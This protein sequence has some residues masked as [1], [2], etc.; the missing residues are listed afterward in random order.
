MRAALAHPL[1]PKFGLGFVIAALTVLAG[2]TFGVGLASADPTPEPPVLTPKPVAPTEVKP[3]F[4][5]PKTTGPL[6]PPAPPPKQKN[7]APKLTG[8]QKVKADEEA[9][10]FEEERELE[11][12]KGHSS[13]RHG[14]G[15]SITNKLSVSCMTE[16]AVHSIFGLPK[17]FSPK[18]MMQGILRIP[19]FAG[20]SPS[21]GITNDEWLT[22]S[23]GFAMLM[24]VVTFTLLH[25]LAAGMLS[26]GS[27]GFFDGVFR[28]VGAAMLILAWPFIFENAAN[29]TNVITSTLF[30]GH[31]TASSLVAVSETAV[32]AGGNFGAGLLVWIVFAVLMLVLLMVK[33]GLVTGLVIAFVGMPLALA[34]WPIP[35]LA[36]PTTYAVRFVAMV[37]TVVI[38]WAVFFR[39][40]GAITTEFRT[41]GAANLGIGNQ[42]LSP[43]LSLGSLLALLSIPRHAVQMWN[44]APRGGALGSMMQYAASGMISNRLAGLGRG[45]RQVP[46]VGVGQTPLGGPGVSSGSA[47]PG[48]SGGP[49]RPGG[50]SGPGG[51]DGPGR[52]AAGSGVPAAGGGGGRSP[53]GAL[54]ASAAATSPQG[55]DGRPANLVSQST[56]VDPDP[57]RKPAPGSSR[58]T[59]RPG[60]PR[61]RGG[62]TRKPSNRGSSQGGSARPGGG[63]A[64]GRAPVR[65]GGDQGSGPTPVRSGGGPSAGSPRDQSGGASVSTRSSSSRPAQAGGASLARAKPGP[66]GKPVGRGSDVDLPRP[67]STSNQSPPP[68]TK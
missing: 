11:E 47:R 23:I 37:F 3:P 67:A 31:E 4:A 48:G 24:A 52:P 34:L 18:K 38:L 65:S 45:A 13:C 26:S 53:A 15:S 50:S 61:G 9:S 49:G 58:P 6:K 12:A 56:P 55:G 39:V 44:V 64:P 59:R 35:S 27:A 41:W 16:E 57:D 8:K 51:P 40:F 22:E 63:Q 17:T 21:E 1:R 33:I 19:D 54:A 32:G 62:G 10:K 46:R 7:L 66:A 60:G 68:S 29:I 36:G 30:D 28:C 2:S 14:F 20:D 25:Y 42:L 5:P 43:L